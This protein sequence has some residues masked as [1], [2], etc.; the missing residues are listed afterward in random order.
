MKILKLIFIFYIL[1]TILTST[2]PEVKE[3]KFAQDFAKTY[4]TSG[5]YFFRMEVTPED[6]IT[7]TT[8]VSKSPKIKVE[9]LFSAT[10]LSDESLFTSSD[11]KTFDCENTV[12]GNENFQKYKFSIPAN[13]K[14]FG[15]SVYLPEDQYFSISTSSVGR[16]NVG[17]LIVII[18]VPL[19]CV[20]LITIYILRKCCGILGGS[21]ATSTV[22]ND[23]NNQG[24][25]N[26]DTAEE[27]LYQS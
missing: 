25:A 19:I 12:S 27:G 2:E 10:F 26:N 11:Y 7:V 3:L 1:D 4:L 5:F 24:S 18:L 8:K 16:L 6:E 17:L 20:I 22:I 13:K 9:F 15:I 23:P 14:Y 21:L